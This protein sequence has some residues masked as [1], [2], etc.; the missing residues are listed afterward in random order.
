MDTEAF[1]GTWVRAMYEPAPP[2]C[3]VARNDI[4]AEYVTF[5]SKAGRKSVISASVFSNCVKAVYTQ[6]G[7]RRVDWCERRCE[8]SSRW[9]PQA[10]QPVTGANSSDQL[11]QHQHTSTATIAQRSGARRCRVLL[12]S[13]VMSGC[14]IRSVLD[15]CWVI[16]GSVVVEVVGSR[17]SGTCGSS[18]SSSTAGS[19]SRSRQEWRK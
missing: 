8:F 5:C 7:L 12:R 15:W 16:G 4:Y 18:N 9:P 10:T 6:T 17:S 19:F 13:V 1:A 14:G 11:P 2:G 3:T